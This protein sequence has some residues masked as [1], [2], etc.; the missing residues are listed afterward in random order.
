[1]TVRPTR[2]VSCGKD[3]EPTVAEFRHLTVNLNDGAWTTTFCGATGSP[4]A[5]LTNSTKPRCP[6]CTEK[7][8]RSTLLSSPR[9]SRGERRRA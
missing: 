6:E 4:G 5:L 1:M 7:A 3:I 2:W 8:S 9:R